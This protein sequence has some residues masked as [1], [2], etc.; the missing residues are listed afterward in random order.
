ML[1]FLANAGLCSE[2]SGSVS[3]MPPELLIKD[4]AQRLE[5]FPGDEAAIANCK[6]LLTPDPLTQKCYLL[7]NIGKIDRKT[8]ISLYNNGLE[9]SKT[10]PSG[11]KCCWV[12]AGSTNKTV[13]DT[14]GMMPE[15][16]EITL[17]LSSGFWMSEKEIT[18]GQYIDY[19]NS[20]KT[21]LADEVRFNDFEEESLPFELDEYNCFHL[22]DDYF[23]NNS[24]KPIS[25]VS[26]YEALE[27]CK[28]L[29]EFD[30][31]EYTLPTEIQW[32]IA[33]KGEQQDQNYF[34]GNE[35]ELLS[36]Y[37]WYN[38][39]YS[40]CPQ[41]T[42]RKKS[43]LFGLYDIYGN[44]WEWCSDWYS[45]KPWPTV[46]IVDPKGPDIVI[47]KVIRGG[48]WQ[49]PAEK[50]NSTYRSSANP[51]LKDKAIGFR[52]IINSN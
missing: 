7:D 10:L 27:F 19:L 24:G 2:E 28:W 49:S 3:K 1:T 23:T 33:S 21:I 30:G 40:L 15:D 38:N 12:P 52:V 46:D 26:Y 25:M 22:S 9:I 50:C 17:S 44:V 20:T 6:K 41:V 47:Q 29:S 43:N 18:V 5:Y 8:I 14:S 36:E 51:D 45:E 13:R 4:M 16:I 31:V 35:L 32:E 39:Y 48:C 37:C 34:F 11:V 42:G